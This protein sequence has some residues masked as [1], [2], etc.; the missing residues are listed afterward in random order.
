MKSLFVYVKGNSLFI[1]ENEDIIKLLTLEEFNKI[2]D[3]KKEFL[4]K[5][6]QTSSIDNYL[7]LW[8]FIIFNNLT[9]YILDKCELEDIDVIL[10][11]EKLKRKGKQVIRVV[12]SVVA[13]DILGN[14]ITCLINSEKYLNGNIKID[15]TNEKISNSENV[16]RI[17]LKEIIEY[18]PNNLNKMIEKL[19]VDLVAFK[20]VNENKKNGNGR[21]ILPIYIDEETLKKKNINYRD[22]LINWTSVAYLKMITQIHDFFKD[23]YGFETKSGLMNDDIMLALIS[24]IDYEVQDYPK[25]LQK[26]IEVGRAT[27]GKC[28][29]IDSIVTPIVITQDLA[30]VLQA[31]DLYSKVTKMIK[32]LQ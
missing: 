17:K 5:K 12:G 20:Y 29:F 4:A 7:Y 11:E 27:K 2:I 9:N 16:R 1:K 13:E 23:Y 6:L 31:K 32:L 22:F 24:L 15:Y 19:K 18:L 30:M 3:E 14:I 28:Y 26:S 8:N 25:G 10:F 21:Y